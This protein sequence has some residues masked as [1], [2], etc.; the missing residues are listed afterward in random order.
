MARLL[1]L[2]LVVFLILLRGCLISIIIWLFFFV[3][4]VGHG[5]GAG[6]SASSARRKPPW[7]AWVSIGPAVADGSD[8]LINSTET[9][10]IGMRGGNR[11]A[12]LH[13]L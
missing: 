12:G 6:T 11:H 1:F 9:N 3:V 2:V 5:A 7:K 8:I 4:L 10:A 13:G